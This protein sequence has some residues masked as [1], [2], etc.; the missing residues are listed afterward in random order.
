[1]S[2][3]YRM[4][5][6]VLIVRAVEPSLAFFRDRL[7]F[8]VQQK[9]MH[10]DVLGFVLLQ[11]DDITI[12]IQSHDSLLEDVGEEAA[13]RINVAISERGAVTL[14]IAVNDVEQI[15]PI[16]ADADVIVPLRKTFYGMHE[17][18]IREPGGHA[19]TFASQLE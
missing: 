7:G 19:V 16:V 5:A 13:N 8:A 6:P 11:K 9:V 15:V 3:E 2:L 10:G 4:V 18:M 1:M 14:Y 12:M 17:I